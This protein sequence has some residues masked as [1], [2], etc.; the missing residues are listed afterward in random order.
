[1]PIIYYMRSALSV[2]I[3]CLVMPFYIL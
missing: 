3:I 1:M 2:I